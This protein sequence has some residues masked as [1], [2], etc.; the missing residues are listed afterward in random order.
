MLRLKLL[1]G[2]RVTKGLSLERMGAVVPVCGWNPRMCLTD[3][4]PL[5]KVLPNHWGVNSEPEP[6]KLIFQTCQL[7]D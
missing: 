5:A 2:K 6:L 3:E 1:E 4:L 7:L